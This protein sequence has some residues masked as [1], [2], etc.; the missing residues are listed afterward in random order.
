MRG[1]GGAHFH[2]AHQTAAAWLRIWQWNI[3]ALVIPTTPEFAADGGN[4]SVPS[5]IRQLDTETPER[6]T[7]LP[8][9]R[10]L[11]TRA[12]NPMDGWR[13]PIVSVGVPLR[14]PTTGRAVSRRNR[15][16]KLHSAGK[17]GSTGA[18]A[19]ARRV[20]S[21]LLGGRTVGMRGRPERPTSTVLIKP[22][23]AW[24]RMS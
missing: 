19:V 20:S 14:V 2:H 3:Q 1:M 23:S 11:G 17:A 4:P 5:T 7:G 12:R 9:T 18:A 10:A 15:K 21:G 16:S 24:S 22:A 13:A 8:P 6:I